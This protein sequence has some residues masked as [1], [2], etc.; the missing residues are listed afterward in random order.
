M[1]LELTSETFNDFKGWSSFRE[2]SQNPKVMNGLNIGFLKIFDVEDKFFEIC[3]SYI[4]KKNYVENKVL[5]NKIQVDIISK[6]YDYTTNLLI[7]VFTRQYE[8]LYNQIQDMITKD[9]FTSKKF[10]DM[11]H[12]LNNKLNGLK[13]LLSTIDY[14]YKNKDGKKTE[15]SFINLVKNY[16][17]YNK[18]INVTYK[19]NSNDLFLDMFLY[20]LFIEEIESNFNT[21]L[22]LNI[23]RIYDF[24]NKFSYSVKNPKSKNGVEYF[25]TELNKKMQLSDD[26]TS[27]FLS[28]MLEIINKKIID[29]SNNTNID[30]SMIEKDIKYVRKLIDITPQLCDKSIF[31]NLY[32]KGLTSRLKQGIKPEIENEFMKSLNPQ[33]DIDIYIKMKNQINDFKL[34]SQHNKYFRNLVVGTKTPKYQNINIQEFLNERN[35]MNFKVCRSYD[36]DYSQFPSINYNLPLEMSIYF[37]IFNAY[38]KDRFNERAL[39]WDYD[40]S[41]GI[42]E[43]STDKEYNVKMNILQITVFMELNKNHSTPVELSTKLNI[44]LNKLGAIL[45]SLIV[46]KFIVKTHISQEIKFSINENFT[47]PETNISIIGVYDKIRKLQSENN[48]NKKDINLPS[49][50]VVRAKIIAKVMIEKNVSKDKIIDDMNNYFKVTIPASYYEKVISEILQNN[51]KLIMNGSNLSIKKNNKSSIDYIGDC[52]NESIDSLDSDSDNEED[53]LIDPVSTESEEKD[54]SSDMDIS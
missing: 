36:W 11:Y 16:S 45:N 44:P 17:S 12:K 34:N 43:F 42:I 53:E 3:N 19:K 13:Y 30:S 9:E 39:G 23:F 38:Y 27:K 22:L 14:S 54:K 15:Y 48:T 7:K 52:D 51:D 8:N 33:D 2:I 40:D 21:E 47:N 18:L 31:I 46:S 28:R 20:E 29:L 49:E 26:T 4:E 37:D 1:S 24:Y 25:N 6:G 5:L 10:I 41:T 35:K 50:T 32:K